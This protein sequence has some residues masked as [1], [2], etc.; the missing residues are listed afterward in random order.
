MYDWNRTIVRGSHKNN[1]TYFYLKDD[2]LKALLVV[3][4]TKEQAA[5]A[6]K[7]AAE[8]PTVTDETPYKDPNVFYEALIG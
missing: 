4:P 5:A 7:L 2:R 8:M 6:E 3:D 1:L